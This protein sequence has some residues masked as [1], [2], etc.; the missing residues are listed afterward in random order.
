MD[1]VRA[2]LQP[3]TH[4]L[5]APLADSGRSLIG[6]YCYKT[7]VLDIDPFGAPECL[8]LAVSKGL[9]IGII[10]ASAIVKIPQLLKIVN[11]QSAAGVSF[12]SYLLESGA[13]L[14]SLSYNIRH[15]FPFS[16]YG[17]TALILAQNIAIAS[18]VLNYSGKKAG[19]AAWLTG[20]A[21]AGT[22]LFRQDIVDFKTL[23]WLQAS[24]GVLGV[25]SKLP[26]IATIWREGGT[27]QLSAF[28]VIN[29]LLGSL[30]RIF[31]TLQEVPDPLI[32]YGF[33]AG[34][35]LNA[36]LA[37]QVI[38]YWNAPASKTKGS[39]KQHQPITA[40]KVNAGES[41]SFAKVAG[42]SPSTRRRG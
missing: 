16:T 19:I 23:A 12:L 17:E 13:Y 42:K 28:A 41:T 6:A 10:G 27:G 7:L 29:Y 32:L 2:V 18:L 4:S 39:K 21:A 24:A 31:T 25:A 15:Q 3:L 11:S 33:I 37:F 8:K 1:S 26:Q 40:E 35:V 34:F 30:S 36:V 14:I 5:P 38:W 20:L 9:S 22:A